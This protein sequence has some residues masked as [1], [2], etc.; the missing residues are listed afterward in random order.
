MLRYVYIA[1]LF[2]AHRGQVSTVLCDRIVGFCRAVSNFGTSTLSL[3]NPQI[4][5]KST[6]V[7]GGDFRARFIRLSP[8][9]TLIRKKF[10]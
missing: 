6:G 4:K 9:S 7:K 1:C 2:G 10:V 5:K 3:T 8:S